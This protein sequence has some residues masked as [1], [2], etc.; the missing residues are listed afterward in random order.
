MIIIIPGH[1]AV[2]LVMKLNSPFSI[3][4]I[5][6]NAIL[7]AKI[8]ISIYMHFMRQKYCSIYLKLTTTMLL[9]LEQKSFLK[10]P[11]TIICETYIPL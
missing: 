11:L 8:E 4:P 10:C 2:S 1:I 7:F 3:D 6:V 9:I 5:T